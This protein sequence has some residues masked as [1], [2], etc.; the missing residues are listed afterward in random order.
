MRCSHLRKID[1]TL[2][3]RR[4]A[5]SRLECCL[6]PVCRTK[7]ALTAALHR[8]KIVQKR[9]NQNSTLYNCKRAT[10]TAMIYQRA[11]HKTRRANMVLGIDR[12][13]FVSL[14]HPKSASAC[15]YSTTDRHNPLASATLSLSRTG[16]EA[17]FRPLGPEQKFRPDIL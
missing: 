15:C 4:R 8:S 10:E 11:V 2:A 12:C 3:T 7:S 17:P 6:G 16:A 14:S 1:A 5:K 13:R 9:S